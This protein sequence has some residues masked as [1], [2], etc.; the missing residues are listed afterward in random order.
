[1]Y[2]EGS[3]QVPIGSQL[4]RIGEVRKG[5]CH[6]GEIVQII[7]KEI[8][9]LS[10]KDEETLLVNLIVETEI[11]KRAMQQHTRG[12]IRVFSGSREE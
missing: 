9:G 1:M 11:P 10:W 5:R 7:V 8:T 6:T 3:Y 4:P 2:V 12:K